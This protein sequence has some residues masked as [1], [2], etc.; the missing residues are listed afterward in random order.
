MAWLSNMP[1]R[2]HFIH[3]CQAVVAI[4]FA[5]LLPL[6]LTIFFG[7]FVLA[8][9]SYAVRKVD[10]VAHNLADLTARKADCNGD[11][12]RTCLS[13]TDVQD[14]FNAGAVLMSPL[15]I[16]SL[17]MTI[18]EIGVLQG[19]QG[20]K[21][22]TSWSITR[23]G[24]M[25][26]CGVAPVVPGGFIAATAPLGAI[27]IADVA[28]KFSPGFNYEMFAW[29]KPLTWTFTRSHYAIARNLISAAPGSDLP[30]GHIRN[31]SGEGVN[32]KQ[33]PP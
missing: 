11:A 30:N 20:R 3:N 7:A 14:I 29:N 33:D 25:R 16:G 9:G 10:L 28:Y 6:L 27:I 5:L 8:R 1:E 4:E 26:A 15:P 24:Q 17:E 19:A 18:S 22:E 13:A 32:C 12:M 23:N 31:Q 2:R 21:V